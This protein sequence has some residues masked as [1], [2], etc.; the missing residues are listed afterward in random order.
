ML[1]AHAA[2]REDPAIIAFQREL[3]RD[4]KLGFALFRL[5]ARFKGTS[6]QQAHDG[7]AQLDPAEGR[8]VK[9][10]LSLRRSSPLELGQEL[11]RS[12]RIT[13]QPTST[14]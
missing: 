13:Y 10:L 8:T 6:H 4:S 2:E 7:R 11:Q 12:Q 5:C 9:M 3:E 14:R 1:V